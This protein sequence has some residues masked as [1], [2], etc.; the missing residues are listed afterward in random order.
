MLLTFLGF[1]QQ[2]ME[3]AKF[4]KPECECDSNFVAQH[5]VN[6]IAKEQFHLKLIL[7]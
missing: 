6:N 4:M 7:Q 1:C 2:A 3:R 5:Q